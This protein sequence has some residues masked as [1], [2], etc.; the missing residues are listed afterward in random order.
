MFDLLF[1]GVLGV[2][3][4][5]EGEG[6]IAGG[7]FRKGGG[8]LGEDREEGFR[9]RVKERVWLGRYGYEKGVLRE[10]DEDEEEIVGEGMEMTGIERY[11]EEL[12]GNLRGGEGEGG[13]AGGRERMEGVY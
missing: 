1:G 11:V 5:Q 2:N 8:S 13:R 3:V 6:L 4:G 10:M 9:F 12:V 7:G